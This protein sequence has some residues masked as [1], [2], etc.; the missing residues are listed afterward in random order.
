M[1]KALF[2]RTG[3]F[4]L[5]MLMGG[6]ATRLDGAQHRDAL[7]LFH[8]DWGVAAVAARS[9]LRSRGYSVRVTGN[10]ATAWRCS[11]SSPPA[12]ARGLATSWSSILRT[13]RQRTRF[14]D[15]SRDSALNHVVESVSGP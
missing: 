9:E 10:A 5:A 13:R 12:P 8:N 3:C 7:I 4:F 2:A 14:G 6:S 15:T 11:G 1:K